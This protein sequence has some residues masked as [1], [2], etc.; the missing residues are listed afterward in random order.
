M[1]KLTR[2]LHENFERQLISIE[3]TRQKMEFLYTNGQICISDIEHVY[4]GLF[5]ELFT[6]FEALLEDLFFG[7]LN[8]S[9]FTRTY[10]V[11]K[12]A[13]ITPKTEI[14]N[15]VFNGKPYVNWLP[16]DNT[17]KRAKLFIISGEPFCRPPNDKITNIS[18][19]HTIRNAIAHKSEYSLEK[20]NSMISSIPLLPSEKTPTGYLRSRPNGGGQTQFEIAAIELKTFTNILCV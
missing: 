3:A 6:D 4:A 11:I 5:I 1:A 16:Y 19:Y 20:F 17:I 18:N 2:R 8:G 7:I 9:L 15:I 14:K 13:T 12:K 10:P